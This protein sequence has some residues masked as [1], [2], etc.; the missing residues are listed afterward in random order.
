MLSAGVVTESKRTTASADERTLPATVV[1]TG[2]GLPPSRPDQELSIDV[3]VHAIGVGSIP[4]PIMRAGKYEILG[5]LAQG[6][7]AEI[8]LARETVQS[9]AS[10]LVVLKF[11][12]PGAAVSQEIGEM[13]LREARV[14]M[15]LAHPH[16]CHVYD[17]GCYRDR[18]Y[19]AMEFIHG[20]TLRDL[21]RRTRDHAAGIPVGVAVRIAA[22]IAEALDYAHG[23]RDAEGNALGL[24]HRDVSPQNIVIAYSGAVKLLDFGV[25][26]VLH[27]PLT[28]SGTLKGKFAYM[29]P[30]QA[31]GG[32]IDGRSDVFSLGVCLWELLARRR[33]HAE[34]SDYLTL[35]AVIEQPVPSLATGRPDLLPLDG[36]CQKALAKPRHERFA[37]AGEMQLALEQYL[38]D[39]REVV[40][41][42]KV[43]AFLKAVYGSECERLPKLDR[44][45]DVTA[46]FSALVVTDVGPDLGTAVGKSPLSS[47]APREGWSGSRRWLVVATIA[48]LVAALGFL[49]WRLERSSGPSPLPPDDSLSS[50]F[51]DVR[52]GPEPPAPPRQDPTAGRP[53]PAAE[54]AALPPDGPTRDVAPQA[55]DSPSPD[56]AAQAKATADVGKAHRARRRGRRP[57][58]TNG[59]FVRDPGF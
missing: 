55:I 47:S 20:V 39:T 24:V 8:Y 9:G 13:F 7:M 51:E 56:P 35:R 57:A 30:E 48:A 43:S 34:T 3:D 59:R 49:L 46:S 23:A 50:G 32:Q 14:A 26:K 6:G 5:R 25:A 19:M 12:R 29:S 40:H 21:F 41:A 42:G 15:V 10:R 17:V 28:Q 31:F 18:W 36:L 38:A 33:L 53:T 37:T 1:E 22:S 52:S 45:A 44:D 54:G 16:I 27:E 58:K 11:V 4:D 2:R